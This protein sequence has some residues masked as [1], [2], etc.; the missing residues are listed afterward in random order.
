MSN[1]PYGCV[2]KKE[3]QAARQVGKVILRNRGRTLVSRIDVI[4]TAVFS[5]PIAVT[6]FLT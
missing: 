1:K 5:K 6:K 3:F 4:N 2:M